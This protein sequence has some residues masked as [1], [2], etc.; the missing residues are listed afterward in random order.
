[1]EWMDTGAPL[2]ITSPIERCGVFPPIVKEK[3]GEEAASFYTKSTDGLIY[4]SALEEA[5][6]VQEKLESMV[7]EPQSLCL[8]YD[9]AHCFPFQISNPVVVAPGT[10]TMGYFFFIPFSAA[11]RPGRIDDVPFA[12]S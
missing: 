7:K 2:G 9:P 4:K 10:M 3:I 12:A 1:L 11:L 8:K 6:W 5:E